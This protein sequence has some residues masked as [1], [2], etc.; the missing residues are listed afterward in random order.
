MKVVRA[1]RGC[2]GIEEARLV[3][4]KGAERRRN[5]VGACDDGGAWGEV[6]GVIRFETWRNVVGGE[7]DGARSGG[8][9]VGG[10]LEEREEEEKA[11][12]GD[13][14]MLERH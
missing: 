11:E 13:E 2:D 10:V 14:R 1:W 6:F 9:G 4:D 3:F 5:R 7:D 12:G 8:L